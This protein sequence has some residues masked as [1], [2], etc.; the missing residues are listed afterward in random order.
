[1]PPKKNKK[2]KQGEVTD[3]FDDMLAGF[4]AADL[5]NAKPNRSKNL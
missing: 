2:S 3:D 5:A 4:R 1:M